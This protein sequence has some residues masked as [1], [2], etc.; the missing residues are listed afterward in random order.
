VATLCVYGVQKLGYSEVRK[1]R[2]GRA[3]Y[4]PIRKV[5]RYK[6]NSPVQDNLDNKGTSKWN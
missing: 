6:H 5:N 4:E 3:Q 2:E 1:R